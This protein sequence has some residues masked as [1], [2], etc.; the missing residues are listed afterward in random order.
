MYSILENLRCPICRKAFK[1]QDQVVLDIINTVI[2]RE[3][4]E[5][6]DRPLL[7]I[8]D[9]GTLRKLV[10]TYEFFWDD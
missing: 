10:A 3:C 2:H 9:E 8:K 1:R 7:P 5:T 6:T 4:Y